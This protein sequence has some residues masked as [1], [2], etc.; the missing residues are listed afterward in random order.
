MEVPR[1]ALAGKS[2]LAAGKDRQSRR[3]ARC[4]IPGS[5]RTADHNLARHNHKH[6]RVEL[7]HIELVVKPI[8]SKLVEHIVA[9]EQEPGLVVSQ[10][11]MA[12]RLELISPVVLGMLA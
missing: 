7:R 2:Q 4:I 6:Q 11:L 1:L 3:L 10:V 9:G 12:G 5:R 8:L